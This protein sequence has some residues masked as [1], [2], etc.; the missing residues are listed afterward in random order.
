M[1]KKI[2]NLKVLKLKL[3]KRV[4]IPKLLKGFSGEKSNKKS[5]NFLLM[6]GDAILILI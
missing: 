5:E 6:N 3:S 4:K 1:Y 2:L